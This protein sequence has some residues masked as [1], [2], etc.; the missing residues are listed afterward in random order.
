M[1]TKK[2]K[3]SKGGAIL[4]SSTQNYNNVNKIKNKVVS[5]NNKT[6]FIKQYKNSINSQKTKFMNSLKKQ[7]SDNNKS[8][9][10]SLE[11]QNK[12]KYLLNNFSTIFSNT[13]DSINFIKDK[14]IKP[15]LSKN[16]IIKIILVITQMIKETDYIRR[17]NDS[18]NDFKDKYIKKIIDEVDLAEDDSKLLVNEY[19][20]L[21]EL[22]LFIFHL[23]KLNQMFLSSSRFVM[24]NKNIELHNLWSSVKRLMND[25]KIWT[26]SEFLKFKKSSLKMENLED[27]KNIDLNEYIKLH[28]QHIQD[29]LVTLASTGSNVRPPLRSNTVSTASTVSQ[30]PVRPPLVRSNTNISTASNGSTASTGSTGSNASTGSTGSNASTVSPPPVRP[31]LVRSSNGSTASQSPPNL[32]P[33]G[34]QISPAPSNLV[35]NALRKMIPRSSNKAN[36]NSKTVVQPV[37]SVRRIY[38]GSGRKRK[39]RRK[40]TKKRR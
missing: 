25:K 30:P 20:Y 33:T 36:N 23:F 3:Y 34:S 7:F 15:Y 31:P 37:P 40:R 26:D 19:V 16:N 2:K 14:T 13:S 6:K 35:Q 18:F 27:E 11:L 24:K 21:G 28:D 12:L 29:E 10:D 8:I 38:K 22:Y 17:D 4:F 5:N 1:I 9:K 39:R 32:L